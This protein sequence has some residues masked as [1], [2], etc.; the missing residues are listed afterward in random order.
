MGA[1]RSIAWKRAEYFAANTQIVWD[2]DLFGERCIRSFRKDAPNTPEI[3]KEGEEA[4]A[5]PAL[6]GWRL[7]VDE[8]LEEAFPKQ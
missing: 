3:F 6:P 7:S 1:E 5:E 8:V 2:V 4:H